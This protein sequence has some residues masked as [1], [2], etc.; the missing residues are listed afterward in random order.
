MLCFVP[1]YWH[2]IGLIIYCVRICCAAVGGGYGGEGLQ[3]D[4][5][6]QR[7][8]VDWSYIIAVELVKQ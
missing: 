5:E 6:G 7:V 3:W 4:G 2:M 1:P 8:S